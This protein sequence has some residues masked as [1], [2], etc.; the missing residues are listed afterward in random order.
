MSGSQEAESSRLEQVSHCAGKCWRSSSSS[1]WCDIWCKQSSQCVSAWVLHDDSTAREQQV[2]RPLMVPTCSH[3]QE[4]RRTWT[5][6]GPITRQVFPHQQ[7]LDYFLFEA[8]PDLCLELLNAQRRLLK[9]AKSFTL[10]SVGVHCAWDVRR[11]KLKQRW[12]VRFS[13]FTPL[14]EK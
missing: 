6:F 12:K 1:S 3:E 14:L 4:Q 9:S 5:V 10:E 2:I 7:K 11:R 8:K 13:D